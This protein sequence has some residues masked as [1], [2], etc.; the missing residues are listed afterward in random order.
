M[1]TTAREGAP[2]FDLTQLNFPAE[3]P[4]VE[5]RDEIAAAIAAHQVVILAGETGSGKTTQ[6]PKICLQVGR[7]VKGMI[8]HTQPRRLA[9]RTV[10]QR[11]AAETGTRLGELVGYQVRFNEQVGEQ[12]QVKLMTDGILLAEIQ[13]DRELNRYDTIIIDEAHERSLNIDFM[14]GYLKRL[15]P[16]RPDLKLII[17]SATIDV[18]SF[19]KHFDDAP[20]I[21]V[22]GRNHPVQTHYLEPA[23]DDYDLNSRIVDAVERILAREYGTPGDML[24]FLSGER[25][26]REL[27]KMLRGIQRSDLQVLPLYSRLSAAEQQR[28]FEPSGRGLRIVLA[29]NVAE[30]SLTVPGIRFVIDPGYAR[31]SR[32]SYQSQVQRLPVEAISQASANQRQG[33]CGRVA[34]G[35]CLRLYSEQDFESRPEF[36]EPEIQRTN[37]ASVV[38]QMLRLR[39]G[40]VEHFPFINA[41]DRRLVRDG[42]K[43]LEELGAVDGRGKLL[44][45]GR[46]M[47]DL[48]VDP[49]LAKMLL[50]AGAAG[51]LREVLII[52][53]GL[54]VQDPRVRPSDH[55]Q[56][57]D[58]Q[59]RRFLHERSDFLAWVALWDYY[60]E[61]RQELSQ[62]QL[63]KM[64][65]KEFLG[66][67][68]MREWRDIHF[69]LTVACRQLGLRTNKEPADYNVVHQALL[70]GLLT[71][72]GNWSEGQEYLGSRNR[73]FQIFPGSS[74]FKRKPKWIVAAEVVET[75][76]VYARTVAEIDPLWSVAIAPHLLKHH[77][78]EPH[79]QP[80]QGRVMAYQRS[81]L[82]GLVVQDRQRVHYGPIQPAESREILIR[83]A[84]VAGRCRQPPAFLRHNQQQ[85]RELEELES[86]LRR[87][88]IVVDPQV[89]EEFYQQQLPDDITTLSRL[90]AWLK[91]TPGADEGLRMTRAQLSLR[92]EQEDTGNMFPDSFEWQDMR[93][94]LS[95]HF[96]PGHVADGVSV[97][98]PVGLLNRVPRHV[99]DWLVPGLLREKCIQMVKGLPKQM[100]K[101]LVPVPDH[102]DRA[103][104]DMPSVDRPLRD[105]LAARLH[106]MSGV[107]VA[108]EHWQA[109]PLEDYYRMNIRVVDESGK[110]L[111]QGR[112]LMQLVEQ[113]RPLT[114]QGLQV[115]AADSPATSGLT[116][117]SIGDLPERWRSRQAGVEIES[118]PALVD[119]GDSVA[120]QLLDYRLQAQV[121]H[122]RGLI[123]LARLQCADPV[124]YIRRQMLKG[125]VASL[126]IAGAGMTRDALIED[127]IDAAI[128]HAILAAAVLPREQLAFTAALE[129]GRGQLVTAASECELLLLNALEPLTQA[130]RLWP[131]AGIPKTLR[132]DIVA[133]V[134]GL[135]SAGFLR[136]TPLQWL[137]HYPRYCKAILQRLQRYAGSPL[138]D[139][140]QLA[141]LTP[142]LS[143]LRERLRDDP[144][145]LLISPP[146][147]HY[148]WMLEEFRVSL[149]AQALGTS[150]PVSAKRLQQQW[151]QVLDWDAANP[152]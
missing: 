61:Q 24:V 40:E 52:S 150:L 35:V 51:C 121:T 64:C 34:A 29:T 99:F 16:R 137:R 93:L 14:L 114:Q 70:A 125:N 3:L 55:Q 17:T 95:Y 85:V 45:P 106:T 36:T 72:M 56:A 120:V 138:K 151:Q 143:Q 78:Y 130:R 142:A 9:A 76:R 53:S 68:R 25:E 152:R 33:R 147:S 47:S 8:G 112:D 67:T 118:W 113:F 86:R 84:L 102:V 50:A 90:K 18:D 31:I 6:L 133:Q 54:S 65:K 139:E 26:I 1:E 116:R 104:A 79:W 83:E 107:K 108:A 44:Q 41:P 89:Q 146:L 110:L 22:S 13:R 20:V 73:K 81:S 119:E 111:E 27:S 77:Y 60:E 117:W 92:A 38:L 2:V 127:L 63:R 101:Q 88:D 131:D 48:P 66:Y 5:R 10:A 109:Q 57:A 23:E 94:A 136:D 140:Q 122:R 71:N 7:G 149:F 124:R 19:S 80:R 21:E 145:A 141:L 74:Q 15:L 30:T 37:L 123:R 46:Q 12:T 39:L 59:H 100:R 58:Q 148:R 144:Q 28:V 115:A 135:F 96:E 97:T 11:I 82:F 32:Y 75:S 134:G 4:V 126:A 42:Y 43:L 91:R 129:A 69:Q 98:V 103:L 49:R 105:V 62:N 132:D 87:R 128:A